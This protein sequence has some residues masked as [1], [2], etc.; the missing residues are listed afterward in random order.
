VG[1]CAAELIREGAFAQWPG[2]IEFEALS[3]GRPEIY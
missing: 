3:F 1:R 2:R